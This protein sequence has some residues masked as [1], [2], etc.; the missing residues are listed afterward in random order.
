MRHDVSKAYHGHCLDAKRN[1]NILC[2]TGHHSS[3]MPSAVIVETTAALLRENAYYFSSIYD[4]PSQLS[5][6][7]KFSV[8]LSFIEKSRLRKQPKTCTTQAS[9]R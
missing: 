3:D 2:D 9:L 7:R 5:K 4:A 8:V 6:L 1:D